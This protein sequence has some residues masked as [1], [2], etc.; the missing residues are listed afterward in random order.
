MRIGSLH[1]GRVLVVHHVFRPDDSL[2]T[3]DVGALLPIHASALGKALLA[4]D[5]QADTL[6][7]DLDTKTYTRHTIAAKDDLVADLDLVRARGWACDIEEL[8]EGEAA[9]AAPIRDDRTVVVGAIG[10]SGAIERVCDPAGLPRTDLVA[11]VR[12][13]ARAVSRDLGARRW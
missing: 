1:E 2:Q 10:V 6:L 9:I 5:L 11:A 3:L 7:A 4:F 12:D 13:A 8:I